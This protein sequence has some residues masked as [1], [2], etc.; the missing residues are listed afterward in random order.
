MLEALLPRIGTDIK[1][2][3]RSE[4]ELLDASGYEDR[5][6]D[7]DELIRILDHDLRLITPTEERLKQE[8]GR[9]NGENTATAADPS[10][11]VVSLQP[12]AF[13]CFQLTHDYLVHSVRDW[14]TRKQQ[15]TRR[16]RAGCAWLSAASHCGKPRRKTGTSR[17]S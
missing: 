7:F 8:G 2:Q 10:D 4:R 11:S 14:V 5:P 9:T 15:E 12:S 3:M 1:G 6:R 16:G 17:R 13:R